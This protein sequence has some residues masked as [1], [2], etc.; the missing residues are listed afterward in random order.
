MGGNKRKFGALDFRRLLKHHILG[1]GN[2]IPLSPS[3]STKLAD[4]ASEKTEPVFDEPILT[5]DITDELWT[6][7]EEESEPCQ[8]I[9]ITKNPSIDDDD[10]IT[11][12]TSSDV[13][14]HI[15]GEQ[16]LINFA[17]FLGKGTKRM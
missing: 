5:R 2:K 12:E 4:D 7:A 9:V 6:K 10:F 14:M 16:G 11:D 3:V 13:K 17:G 15:V 8:T 1:G